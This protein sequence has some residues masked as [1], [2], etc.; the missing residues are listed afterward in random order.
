MQVPVQIAF[1]NLERSEVIE[2]LIE[3]KVAWLERVY[4]RVTACRVVV[5]APHRH[6]REGNQYLVRI[7][8]AVPGG[9]IVVNRQP[10]E[11]SAS[12]NLPTTIRDAFDAARGQLEGYVHRLKRH[13]KSHEAVPQEQQGTKS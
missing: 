5:E 9:A 4:D 6:H 10:P 1:H 12:R 7:D 13:S 2:R 3:E 11:H 8:L